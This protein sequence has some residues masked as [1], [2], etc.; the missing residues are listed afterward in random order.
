MAHLAG[1]PGAHRVRASTELRS[2]IVGSNICVVSELQWLFLRRTK[3]TDAGLEHL[4]GMSK[5]TALYLTGSAVSDA[6]MDN[7]LLAG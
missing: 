5:L 1:L 2:E 4:E 3:V 6:G 7:L